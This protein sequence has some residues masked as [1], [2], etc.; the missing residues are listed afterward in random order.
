MKYLIDNDTVIDFMQDRGETRARIAAITEAG[1]DISL[2]AV[3]VAELHSGVNE[4][5]LKLFKDWLGLLPYWDISQQ[6]AEQAGS[7]RKTASAVGR[8]LHIPDCLL[9]SCARENGA[10]VLTS[11]TKDFEFI[12]DVS[13]LSL[14]D[15]AA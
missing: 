13:V 14:R 11:N 1:D 5:N 8:T 7:F 2:C 15:K 6:A 4:K 3:T 10:I 9:A 12:K